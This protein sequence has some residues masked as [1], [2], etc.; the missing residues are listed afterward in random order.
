MVEDEVI[1][2][3]KVVQLQKDMGI[4]AEEAVEVLV[5]V[6]YERGFLGRL[7]IL[8]A[9]GEDLAAAGS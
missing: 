4:F 3:V 8:V 6:L 7:G 1:G 9:G 2:V 5:V